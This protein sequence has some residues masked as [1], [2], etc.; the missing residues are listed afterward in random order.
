MRPTPKQPPPAAGNRKSSLSL[1]VDAAAHAPHV[2][3]H[4]SATV[5]K[6]NQ[7]SLPPTH[8]PPTHRMQPEHVSCCAA[9]A[10]AAHP[11]ALGRPPLTSIQMHPRTNHHLHPAASSSRPLRPVHPL[12]TASGTLDP[13]STGS[14]SSKPSDSCSGCSLTQALQVCHPHSHACALASPNVAPPVSHSAFFSFPDQIQH[15]L[16]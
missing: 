2:R 14:S 8:L 1:P 3:H 7:K 5:S 10:A 13:S 4:A 9:A 16:F 6:T 15:I 12:R 11:R